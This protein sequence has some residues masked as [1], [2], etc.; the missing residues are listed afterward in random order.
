MGAVAQVVDQPSVKAAFKNRKIIS[1]ALVRS[2]LSVYPGQ[3]L[4]LHVQLTAKYCDRALDKGATRTGNWAVGQLSEAQLHYAANDVHATLSIYNALLKCA[5]QSPSDF[6]RELSK[7]G[8]HACDVFETLPVDEPPP[9]PIPVFGQPGNRVAGEVLT[10]AMESAGMRSQFLRAYREWHWK[11]VDVDTM[12]QK[13]SL[14][15]DGQSLKPATV[16]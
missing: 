4:I 9:S 16:M 11:R 8:S 1:L 15:T 2:H 14:K 13:L 3:M 7:I 12:C 5:E 10:Q 6:S